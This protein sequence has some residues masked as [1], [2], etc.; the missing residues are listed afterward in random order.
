MT[1]PATRLA[2][3]LATFTVQNPETPED[4]RAEA[5]RQQPT[6]LEFWRA[7]SQAVTLVQ[8]V[9]G[10]IHGLRASGV[11]VN[12]YLRALP[13]RYSAVFGFYAPWKSAF[14]NPAMRPALPAAGMDSLENLLSRP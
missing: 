4:R 6:S 13:V 2:A 10:L 12:S 14:G 3:L 8:E 11:R 1:N 7:H 9:D 5:L